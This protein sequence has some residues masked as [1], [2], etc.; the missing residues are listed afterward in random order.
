MLRDDT[1][2]KIKNITSGTVLA[3][4]QDTC[5]T[6][7]NLLCSSF[8]TS[9]TVKENFEGNVVIKEEYVIAAFTK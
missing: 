5:T 3:G 8:A 4:Q 6:A 7:R 2:S 1:Q 9:T